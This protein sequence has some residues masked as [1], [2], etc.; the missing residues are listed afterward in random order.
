MEDESITGK[1]VIEINDNGNVSKA[2]YQQTKQAYS[3][4]KNYIGEL[5]VNGIIAGMR[6][7]SAPIVARK[8]ILNTSV[9]QLHSSRLRFLKSPT[10][11]VV[12]KILAATEFL[13]D[14]HP[15]VPA[16]AK[17]ARLS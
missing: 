13:G 16:R 10:V 11:S 14:K 8:V 1:V 5:I 2:N 9:D 17:P 15:S 7:L 3:R 4:N 6:S 12:L